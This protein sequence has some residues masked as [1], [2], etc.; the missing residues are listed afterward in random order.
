[1][2]LQRDR[3]ELMEMIGQIQNAQLMASIK[4]VVSDLLNPSH[5]F[6]LTEDHQ[7]I[8]DERM[9]KYNSGKGKLFTWEEVV[10]EVRNK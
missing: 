7:R 6:E 1:M 8:L 10:K 4:E 3:N 5:G 2:D 9:D